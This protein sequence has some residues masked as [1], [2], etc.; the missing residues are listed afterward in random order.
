[1]FSFWVNTSVNGRV[2]WLTEMMEYNARRALEG[3]WWWRAIIGLYQL[4]MLISQL[5]KIKV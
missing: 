1:M 5:S 4:V 2:S 3:V